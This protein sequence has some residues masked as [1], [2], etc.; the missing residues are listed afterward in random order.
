MGY[1]KA[2]EQPQSSARPMCHSHTM[3]NTGREPATIRIAAYGSSPHYA[4]RHGRRNALN[5]LM[6]LKELKQTFRD[7]LIP[8]MKDALSVGRLAKDRFIPLLIYTWL[9]FVLNHSCFFLHTNKD[10]IGMHPQKHSPRLVSELWWQVVLICF[11]CRLRYHVTLVCDNMVVLIYQVFSPETQW[12]ILQG[13]ANNSQTYRGKLLISCNYVHCALI[14]SRLI[15][16]KIYNEQ[17]IG[18]ILVQRR[19]DLTD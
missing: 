11:L 7:P 8:N 14:Y 15:E 6:L 1:S 5:A 9:L 13:S 4:L 19:L 17:V 16:H 12:S 18:H 3:T 2:P 10:I